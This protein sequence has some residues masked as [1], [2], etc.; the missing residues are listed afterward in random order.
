MNTN[1]V[2]FGLIGMTALVAA[3]SSIGALATEFERTVD[4]KMF[5][6]KNGDR[7]GLGGRGWFVDLAISFEHPLA[8]TGFSGFQL[9]GPAV[10]NNVAPF[11]GTF[12]L[13]IDDRLPGL[14]VL[15]DTTAGGA[16]SC[17][18]IANLF[19]LTGVTDIKEGSTE[20]WD[21]WLV[22]ASN[23]GVNTVSNILVA[24]AADMNQDGIFNDAPAVIPDAN[25]D[26]VCD[27][28]D[29]KAFGLASN[30]QKAKF[31]INP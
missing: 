5:A 6:P 9:T 31:F 21:T 26:G 19:N 20:L 27:K 11:P 29:L 1:T 14:I 8:A 3:F 18:N 22:G 13:G 4:I 12:S 25:G 10:H 28:S 17:Q 24:V 15:L 16:K 30:I 7:V 2:K 23:F